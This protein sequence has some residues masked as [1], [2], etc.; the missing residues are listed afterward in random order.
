MLR[1]TDLA[2]TKSRL[3][4]RGSG[5][6]TGDGEANDGGIVGSLITLVIG[7]AALLVV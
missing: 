1:R 4:R 5:L 6:R 2:A 7:V 3:E